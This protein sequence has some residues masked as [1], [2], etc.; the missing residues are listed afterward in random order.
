VDG[1]VGRVDGAGGGG[2]LP[3]GA[4]RLWRSSH[5][6]ASFALVTGI[7]VQRRRRGSR[8]ASISGS[9]S[10]SVQGRRV[11]SPVDVPAGT[12]ITI[13][14]ANHSKP[15][16][17]RRYPAEGVR[18]PS[19]VPDATAY[20]ASSSSGSAKG[21]LGSSHVD[22]SPPRDVTR[23]PIIGQPQGAAAEAPRARAPSRPPGRCRPEPEE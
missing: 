11:S 14:M 20:D 10:S 22:T 3:A 4:A 13:R 16:P 1:R 9:T 6:R 5:C 8:Y 15:K 12:V 7:L 17:N 19:A 2:V 23:T 21:R 18:D